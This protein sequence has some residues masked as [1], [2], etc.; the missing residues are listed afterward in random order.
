MKEARITSDEVVESLTNLAMTA[1]KKTELTEA[2]M[3]LIYTVVEIKDQF[4]GTLKPD[5]CFIDIRPNPVVRKDKLILAFEIRIVMRDYGSKMKLVNDRVLVV[6]QA[7]SESRPDNITVVCIRQVN[8]RSNTLHH[9][10]MMDA[11]IDVQAVNDS[12][13]FLMFNMVPSDEEV[14]HTLH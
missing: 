11:K 2:D 9:N 10:E 5:N 4:V 12:F 8:G 1:L 13:N 14:K 3:L 7:T 6:G